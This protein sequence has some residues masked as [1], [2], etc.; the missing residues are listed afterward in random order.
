MKIKT[1]AALI[2][3]TIFTCPLSAA[4]A[5]QTVE[6]QFKEMYG[7]VKQKVAPRQIDK[8]ADALS[9]E[10]AA[11][12]NTPSPQLGK[13]GAV[14]YPFGMTIP[15]IYCRPLRVTDIELEAGETVTNAPFIGDSINWQILPST[16]GSGKNLTFHIM[17]KPSMLD[18]ATNLIVHTDRRSYQF[19]LISSE[20]FY[21][22]HVAF[23]YPYESDNTEWETFLGSV[24]SEKEREDT[25]YKLP[26][27]GGGRAKSASAALDMN[28]TIT[29]KTK[30]VPWMPTRAYNDGQKTFIE[31]PNNLPST[32]APVFMLLRSGQR[33]MV[34]YRL[35]ENTYVIDYLVD[36]G[37]LVAGTGRG[38]KTVIISRGKATGNDA[39]AVAAPVQNTERINQRQSAALKVQ[40][41]QEDIQSVKEIRQPQVKAP[42]KQQD[43]EIIKTPASERPKNDSS[44][45]F[46]LSIFNAI[47]NVMTGGKGAEKPSDGST[48]AGKKIKKEF[49]FADYINEQNQKKEQA[50]V[51]ASEDVK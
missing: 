46:P 31:F 33:E 37:I 24:F 21:T 25:R 43:T 29:A 20:K 14:V 39:Q 15:R 45:P 5:T 8:K 44:A 35:I 6:E 50:S 11:G 23:S 30:D 41:P 28:Y 34:N 40:K 13:N 26:E 51:P 9:K 32:E 10:Y 1:F 47:D 12:K 2:I 42:A 27:V 22:P 19:D 38:A 18:I 36:R 17:V 3:M 16:S 4:T 7:T 48:A 49:T